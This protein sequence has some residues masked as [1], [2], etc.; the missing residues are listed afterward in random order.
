MAMVDVK[1][2]AFLRGERK[3]TVVQL[4]ENVF[5]AGGWRTMALCAAAV[6]WGCSFTEISAAPKFGMRTA[7]RERLCSLVRERQE[8][9][10]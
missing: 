9:S 8:I 5:I 1:V 10:T 6:V 4:D 2:S 7:D 3:E